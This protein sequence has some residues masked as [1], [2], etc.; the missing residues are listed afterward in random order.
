MKKSLAHLP[1]DKQS[2]VKLIASEIRDLA[3]DTQIIIL[4]GSYARTH[5]P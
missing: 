4:F 2:E 3:E 5:H 1:K